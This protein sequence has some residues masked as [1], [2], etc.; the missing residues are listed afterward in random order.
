MKTKMYLDEYADA[1][2]RSD[3]LQQRNF[4]SWQYFCQQYTQEAKLDG[5]IRVP[6]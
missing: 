6:T 5:L 3:A 2:N 4:W 1:D